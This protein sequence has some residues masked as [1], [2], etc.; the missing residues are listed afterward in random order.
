MD[1]VDESVS[2]VLRK[3]RGLKQSFQVVGVGFSSFVM[4]LIAVDAQGKFFDEEASIT[5][6]CNSHE[7]V[8]ECKQIREELGPEGLE[9]ILAHMALTCLK[10]SSFRAI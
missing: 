6:A 8:N 2:S 9:M 3:L 5:Y 4:N 10:M 1:A 7:V